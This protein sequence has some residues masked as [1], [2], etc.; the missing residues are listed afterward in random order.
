M[1]FS[2]SSLFNSDLYLPWKV[3]KGGRVDLGLAGE[4]KAHL[5]NYADLASTAQETQGM[6]RIS[7]NSNNSNSNSNING[8]SNNSNSSSNWFLV[9]RSVSDRYLPVAS[10]LCPSVCLS[11]WLAD[12]LS[13]CQ[14]VCLSVCLSVCV[15]L[16]A[17]VNLYVTEVPNGAQESQ[18]KPRR[19][20]WS[21]RGPLSTQNVSSSTKKNGVS[22][23][24]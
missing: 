7:N 3:K 23:F 8:Y 9:V 16:T 20:K 10:P 22:I 19:P 6:P 17:F 13:V 12:W 18:M 11:V 15:D 1:C 21:T 24:G 2:R 4:R 5:K 14:F